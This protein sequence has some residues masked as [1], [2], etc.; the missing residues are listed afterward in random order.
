[1]S[2][3]MQSEHQ[4]VN[5]CNAE[6]ISLPTFQT[7]QIRALILQQT[8]IA[9]CLKAKIIG[10]VRSQTRIR[11]SGTTTLKTAVTYGR[12]RT[13]CQ[14]KGSISLRGHRV[15]STATPRATRQ[16]ESTTTS[17]PEAN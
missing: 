1:M 13:P 6:V 12:I 14:L 2:D 5:A 4:A 7:C 15:S 17:I 3:L 9:D 8:I 11:A 16:M 10:C